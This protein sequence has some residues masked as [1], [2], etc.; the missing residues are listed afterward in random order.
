MK[1]L[2]D[3]WAIKR[4]A[5][6]KQR[7]EENR[8]KRAQES[9]E[10]RVAR[11]NHNKLLFA[12]KSRFTDEV[13]VAY[14]KLHNPKFEVGQRVLLNHLAPGDNW[15]GSVGQNMSHTPFNGPVEVIIDSISLDTGWLW[16][17]IDIWDN[18]E[19]FLDIHGEHHYQ[20]FKERVNTFLKKYDYVIVMHQYRIH[21]E[22]HEDEYWRYS[23]REYQL[24][25]PNSEHGKT[26][27]RLDKLNRKQYKARVEY[28]RIMSDYKEVL[29]TL[30]LN[31]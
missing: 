31:Y 25:D 5:N 10:R 4:V 30:P 26:L 22:G 1:K 17:Q 23:F 29:E 8:I 7:E 9:E 16:E 2:L 12:L 3:N 13:E 24:A 28:E 14:E 15:H 20:K 21:V 27:L 18:M 11:E 6:S 19:K